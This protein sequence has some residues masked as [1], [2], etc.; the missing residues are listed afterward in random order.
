MPAA[1]SLPSAALLGPGAGPE[2]GGDAASFRAKTDQARRALAALKRVYDECEAD[3]PAP[4]GPV[5]RAAQ[6][7][8]TASWNLTQLR[9]GAHAMRARIEGL[10]RE[11]LQ[12]KS[13]P[14]SLVCR[15]ENDQYE[16]AQLL[17]QVLEE[18]ALEEQ[19]QKAEAALKQQ[20][21][22]SSSLSPYE[23][24]GVPENEG[25]DLIPEVDFLDSKVGRDL[26]A[27]GLSVPPKKHQENSQEQ[28]EKSL[29]YR[30]H[31]LHFELQE[32]SRHD[33]VLRKMRERRSALNAQILALKKQGAEKFQAVD[34]LERQ[35]A[36]STLCASRSSV[37]ADTPGGGALTGAVVPGGVVPTLGPGGGTGT[38]VPNINPTLTTKT[39][40]GNTST[41][42][43]TTTR[44]A[45]AAGAPPTTTV[46]ADSDAAAFPRSGEGVADPEGLMLPAKLGAVLRKFRQIADDGYDGGVKAER[47]EHSARHYILKTQNVGGGAHHLQGK[48]S[49]LVQEAEVIVQVRSRESRGDATDPPVRVR[50]REGRGDAT[51]R[52][53]QLAFRS[54]TAGGGDHHVVVWCDAV[55]KWCQRGVLASA[56]ENDDGDD[57]WVRADWVDDLLAGKITALEVVKS[58]REY[59]FP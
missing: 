47:R 19:E 10:R 22:I 9:D 49:V 18:R 7:L 20:V 3:F 5:P 45:A 39:S 11:L 13:G 32:R 27:K 33:L 50:S 14:A 16:E 53:V 48:E 42:G 21:A 55:W 24:V 8:Q 57:A 54:A 58:V 46:V 59:N 2:S 15:Y 31:W 34:R 12:E 52:S 6:L 25:G 35:L 56:R 41:V 28:N 23:R 1:L 26:Q 43:T 40:P 38:T 51:D 36:G 29:L 17:Q 37:A 30:L 44:P 4:P